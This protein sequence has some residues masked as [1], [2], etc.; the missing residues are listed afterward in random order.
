MEHFIFYWMIWG[1]N[2]LVSETSI[3]YKE[4]SLPVSSSNWETS[5]GDFSK[6]DVYTDPKPTNLSHT[7]RYPSCSKSQAGRES[8]QKWRPHKNESPREIS[9]CVNFWCLIGTFFFFFVLSSTLTSYFWIHQYK[10]RHDL[11]VVEKATGIQDDRVNYPYASS[12]SFKYRPFWL[13]FLLQTYPLQFQYFQRKGMQISQL[14]S[15]SLRCKCNKLHS[16]CWKDSTLLQGF[17]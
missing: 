14:I 7:K 12:Q 13:Q 10:C 5:R 4:P 16:P 6:S 8:D 9:V 11:K 1:E 17:L 2:P 3:Y 15:A